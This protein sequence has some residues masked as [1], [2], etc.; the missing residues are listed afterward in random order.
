MLRFWNILRMVPPKRFLCL[1]MK[2]W[3]I[4]DQGTKSRRKTIK[5][6]DHQIT[7]FLS[8]TENH[9]TVIK[10]DYCKVLISLM[11]MKLQSCYHRLK[12]RSYFHSTVQ[13]E[14]LGCIEV[15][16]S[17]IQTLK[18]KFVEYNFNDFVCIRRWMVVSV[19]IELSMDRKP[20]HRYAE[21]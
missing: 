3:R 11:N 2:C 1:W 17:R 20:S 9:K 12:L 10:E 18:K 21:T 4:W 8:T 16:K 5:L 14:I 6:I 15:F 19:A 13:W 7:I